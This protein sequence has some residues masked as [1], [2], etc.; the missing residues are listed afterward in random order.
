MDNPQIGQRVYAPALRVDPCVT[1]NFSLI[2][3]IVREL[4]GG[5]KSALVEFDDSRFG[6]KRLATSLL[7]AEVG[8][9]IVRIG[10]FGSELE[11][12]DPLAQSVRDF[13]RLLLPPDQLRFFQVRT[14]RE[15][16]HVFQTYHPAYSHWILVGH[17]ATDHLVLANAKRLRAQHFR[18]FIEQ[19]EST[20][21]TFIS[22]CCHS[23]ERGFAQ[24]ISRSHACKAFVAPK[25]PG[26]GASASQF[27]Q[28]F[29]GYHF[30]DG[31]TIKVAFKQTRKLT[32]G[33][34]VF[35]LWQNG[36]FIGQN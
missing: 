34:A 18:D 13:C 27:A 9:M 1:P 36:A 6:L 24:H 12:L 11:F 23:G 10:D 2:K 25:G 4:P 8:V 29:L 21:K 26:Y 16:A 5:S 17:G 35:R 31:R 7:H 14:L 28:S 22:L 32:P 30:L 15:L 3:G 19:S 33:G 20:P